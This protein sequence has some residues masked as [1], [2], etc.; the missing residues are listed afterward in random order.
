V[1][2]KQGVCTAYRR[3]VRRDPDRFGAKL[4]TAA[5]SIFAAAL[6]SAG[7]K[8]LAGRE[9]KRNSQGLRFGR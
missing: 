9:S 5:S 7:K 4:K 3:V 2:Q 1:A 6:S 8:L